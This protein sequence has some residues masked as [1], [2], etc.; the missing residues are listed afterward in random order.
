MMKGA[1]QSQHRREA[2]P[3]FEWQKQAPQ[4]EQQREESLQRRQTAEEEVEEP[5][6]LKGSLLKGQPMNQR[7][8]PVVQV[9]LHLHQ[10]VPPCELLQQ[11]SRSLLTLHNNTCSSCRCSFFA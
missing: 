1:R 6:M 4:R 11:Q 10:E 9:V 5:K 2:P 3:S 7:V 8:E